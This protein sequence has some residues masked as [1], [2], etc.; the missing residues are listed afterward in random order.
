MYTKFEL[1]Q[2][3][4]KLITRVKVGKKLR[5]SRWLVIKSN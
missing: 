3:A 1:Y 4:K 5:C 2:C